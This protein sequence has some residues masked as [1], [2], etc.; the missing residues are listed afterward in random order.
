MSFSR[1]V[2]APNSAPLRATIGASI[3]RGDRWRTNDQSPPKNTSST[4][5]NSAEQPTRTCAIRSEFELL[6]SRA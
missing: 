2:S 1:T 3:V 5:V 6:G 4:A